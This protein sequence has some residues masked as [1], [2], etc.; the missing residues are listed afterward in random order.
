[1]RVDLWLWAVRLHKTRSKATTACK[2][3]QITVNDGRVKPSRQIR[4][5]DVITAKQGLMIKTVRVLATL[6]KRVGAKLVEA[7]YEDLTP[8]EVYAQAAAIARSNRDSMLRRESGSGRPTKKERRDL[9]ELM[10][11]AESEIDFFQAMEAARKKAR[12]R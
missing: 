11:E 6:E 12:H 8:P 5:G 2:N 9:E 10:V 4:P 3:N 1:M 7:Y